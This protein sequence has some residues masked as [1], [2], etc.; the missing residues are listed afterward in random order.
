VP[1]LSGIGG[2]TTALI[3]TAVVIPLVV[4]L[5][6]KAITS[7]DSGARVPIVEIA[8]LRAM[9]HFRAL[10]TPALEGL[11]QAVQRREFADGTTIIRQGDPGDL[12]YAISEGR[13]KVFVDGEQIATRE[14]PEGLG[15][16]ALLRK[17]PRSATVVA[18]GPVVLYALDGQQ[19]VTVVTGHD[20]TRRKAEAVADLRLRGD[21][22]PLV[23]DV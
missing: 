8:L 10:P 21:D 14:R 12:F 23:A 13:V 9:P 22:R 7:L 18:D 19:F 11:A 2:T 17:V 20:P 6:A 3:G 16:I 1:I 15:E 4:L 5:G